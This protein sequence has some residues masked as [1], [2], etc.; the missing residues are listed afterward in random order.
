MANNQISGK[1]RST[2]AVAVLAGLLAVGAFAPPGP[3]ELVGRAVLPANT[4]SPGP[5]SGQY[6]TPANGITPPFVNKQPVQGFS[7]VIDNHD[8]TFWAM[9]D[10][11]YGAIENSADFDLRVYRIRP[12]FKTKY[13]GSG[14]ID[15][16]D[17]IELH[18]PDHHV[19][20][21]I[22]NEFTHQRVLTG[23]DF[24]IESMQRSPDGTLWIGDEFGPFLLHVGA[25]GRLLEAP[26]SLPDFDNPGKQVRAPQNPFSEESSAL[27]IMNAV[28]THAKLHGNANAPVF[29]PWDVMLADG[30]P[31]TNVFNRISPYLT[32][33]ANAAATTNLVPA[34]SELWNVK[35]MQ[36]AG[37][38]VVCWTVDDKPR[39]LEL[40]TLG[41]NGIISDRSDLLLQAAQEFNGGVFLDSDGLIDIA[42]FDAQGHRGSRNLRPESTL[43]AFEVAMDNLMTTLETDI[44]V[45]KD[46][47]GL[48]SHD[49]HIMAQKARLK[50]GAPYTDA[51]QILIRDFTAAQIRSALVTDKVFRGPTQENDPR[52]S[53]VTLAF[54]GVAVPG[55][56]LTHN[57]DAALEDPVLLAARNAIYINPLLTELFTFVKF[58]AA[59]YDVGGPGAGHPQA[60]KRSKNAK[61]IR[62]NLETKIN[63]RTDVDPLDPGHHSYADLTFGPMIMLKAIGD[64][65]LAFGWSDR[66][67][68]QSFDF[69]TL[70]L[71]HEH[72][73]DIRTVFLWG[74]FAVYA[75]VTHPDSDDGTN[76]QPQAG[77]SNTKWL[78]G[79]YWPYR[80]TSQ[81]TPFR[82]ATSGGF[83][84]M[85]M[86]PNHKKLLPL[87]EKPLVGAPAGTLYIHEFDIAS[88]QY[89][90][91][92]YLYP[93]EPLGVSIGEF[94]LFSS[95]K[96]LV[97]ERDNNMGTAAVFKAV[98]E[99][100]L[101]GPGA[102]VQK[103]LAVDLLNIA[104]PHGISA[105][106]SPGDYGLGN[107]FKMP[108]VTIESVVIF[109]RHHIGIVNDNNYPFSRGRHLGTGAPDDNE[110]ILIQLDEA[111][112]HD[113]D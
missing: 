12:H 28:R 48:L 104:D 101:E 61:R 19:P 10:N 103:K 89:T 70:L 98:Y 36:A 25:N 109:D 60:V 53:P 113:D 83:E 75:D 102:P 55:A 42:K 81:G 13:G 18:D 8:G 54:F 90:G 67:D 22:V 79:L 6:I 15:V 33:P 95:K 20:F 108:F 52:L 91:K 87:L 26:I 43:P 34:S 94:Q 31:A 14:K 66:A 38:P 96:G 69:R 80:S 41:V 9:C 76:L 110:F 64:V 45:T 93:L 29:S 77:E 105:G 99:I 30:N 11:G 86:T 62:F 72:Y 3:P 35:Q 111:L 44:G 68:I 74:D 7:S 32:D 92:R 59:Y 27:R 40:M 47:I 82:A 5:H 21:A 39:M 49:P 51:T 78:A 97:I 17:H 112:G 71:C 16:V 58:Y 106:G 4:F 85:A 73:P 100:E 65:I 84:G 37:Y 57:A 50:S 56:G 63:P 1:S 107:P 23:A 2:I 46:K 24:D 88:R